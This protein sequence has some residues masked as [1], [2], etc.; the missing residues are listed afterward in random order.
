VPNLTVFL[1]RPHYLSHMYNLMTKIALVGALL[2]AGTGASAQSYTNR[3]SFDWTVG[4]KVMSGSDTVEYAFMGGADLPQWSR[5]DLNLDGTEDLAIFDRQG[6]RWITFLAENNQ[7][8]PAPQYAEELPAVEYWGLF[9]DY[10]CDGKKDLFA[11]VLGGM[12]VWENTSTTDSL[13]FTWALSGNY[14]TTD[15]GGTTTNLYNFSSDI[16]AIVDIDDDGDLDVLTFGQRSTIEW[17]E[18]QTSCGLDFSM[19]TTCW[20]RFEENLATNNLT[21]NGCAGVQKMEIVGKTSVGMHAGSTLLVLNLDGDTLKDVLIGDVSFTNLV[22]AYNGGHMDSAFMTSKDTLYPTAN[23]TN[24]RYFPAPF[25]E[26]LNFDGTPDLMVSPNLNGS[27]NTRNAWLYANTG[28]AN[29]PS[30]S[31]PDSS[32]LVRDMLDLGSATKPALVDL[33]FD[34]DFDLVVGS[35]GK[36]QG[37]STYKSK[38]V[39]YKNTGTNTNPAFTLADSDFANAGYNNLG[40]ELCPTFADLDADLDPDMIVGAKNGLIYYY[41]NTGSFLSHSFTYRGAIQSID[42]GN[43]ATP[44]LGDVNGDG[45]ADLLIGNEAGTVAYYEKTGTWPNLFILNASQWAGIDMG[46]TTAPS[47]HSA[48]ALIY[49]TD[50]TLFIG[51]E[52]LGV[53]QKDSLKIITSGATASVDLNL[54]GGTQTSS[55]RIETPFGGSKRNGRT[56][57][58]FT[59]DELINAGGRF[60]QI[61]TIGFEVGTNNSL[62]LTQGFNIRFKHISDT[63]QTNFHSQDLTEVYSGIRVMTTGWND[64]PLDVPFTWNGVDHLLVEICFSKHAQTGDI[65][66]ILQ[67]TPFYAT[68]YG[69]VSSWNGIT[70]NGCGMPYGGKLKL[71]PNMRF[72]LVPTLRDMDAHFTAAGKRLHPAV[73]DLNADG[74]PD[75]ILGNMSGGLHYFEG[76]AFNNISVEETP[77][78]APSCIIFPNPTSNRMLFQCASSYLEQ[79]HLISL[80]GEHIGTLSTTEENMLDLPAGIYIVVLYREDGQRETHRLIVQ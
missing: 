75:V 79:A 37:P 3:L 8:I 47:G 30:W 70:N 20:G 67:S 49:G 56:Q 66:V 28:A 21:L 64:I 39:Y 34:G 72:N 80:Q 58:I 78:Q 52:D 77:A 27:I 69:D 38:L 33:D 12:G 46:S 54:G 68:L 7:W 59:K 41:E 61:E 36:Y 73:A 74:Y 45:V 48:P 71:R 53:V 31:A 4:P 17:H 50:T 24:I 60:G 23:P 18:G 76:K 57:I 2:L 22:A 65:P 29:N 1:G 51:S 44:Y 25:Y 40:E 42:V 19:N 35:M 11:F 10:N 6:N 55:S 16:P 62:Y 43:H 63:A 5:I 26:D 32:F 14:L 15:A 9:R 13:S